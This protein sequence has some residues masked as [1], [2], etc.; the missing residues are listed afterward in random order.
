VQHKSWQAACED[1]LSS[2]T[3]KCDSEILKVVVKMQEGV[4]W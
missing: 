2:S 4:G 1:A 3:M